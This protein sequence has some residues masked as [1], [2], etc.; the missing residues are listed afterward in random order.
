MNSHRTIFQADEVI[1]F[2]EEHFP[3]I[4]RVAIAS[5]SACRILSHG[6]YH[7]GRETLSSAH[8]PNY[9]GCHGVQRLA[10]SRRVLVTTE[11]GFEEIEDVHISE[12]NLA[13]ENALREVK[14]VEVKRTKCIEG[15]G[16]ESRAWCSEFGSNPAVTGRNRDRLDHNE[17]VRSEPGVEGRKGRLR[18][19]KGQQC[20]TGHRLSPIRS[21]SFLPIFLTGRPN[22]WLMASK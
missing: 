4:L 15:Q 22:Y 6:H 11:G 8:T 19:H 9:L 14:D 3:S 16:Q 21:S 20:Y 1:Q 5:V 13:T 18:D 17:S 7:Y 12:C 10:K 2:Q